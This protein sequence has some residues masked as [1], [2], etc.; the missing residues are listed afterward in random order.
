[1]LVQRARI[2]EWSEDLTNEEIEQAML[3]AI[4]ELIPYYEYI[5]GKKDFIKEDDISYNVTN[6]NINN[7]DKI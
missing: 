4:E 2:I 5:I 7:F 1:M 6:T 3:E